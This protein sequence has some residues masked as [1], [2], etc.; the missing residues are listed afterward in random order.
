[1]KVNVVKTANN[2]L[3][4]ADEENEEK[5][6]N[7]KVAE[8]Y[9]VDIRVNQNYQLHKKIFAF[10]KFCTQ[11]YYGDMDVTKIQIEFVRKKLIVFAG[12]FDQVFLRDGVQFELVPRSLEYQ[13]MPPEER[14]QC[15]KDL[16]NAALKHVFNNNIDKVTENQLMSFF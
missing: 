11:H 2:K 10:F 3:W 14:S 6:R 1:M 5:L 13:K 16:I 12:Y 7:M 9:E 8:V 4:A 15:Y